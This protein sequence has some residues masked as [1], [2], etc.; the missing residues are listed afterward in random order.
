[1]FPVTQFKL[2][3]YYIPGTDCHPACGQY[4]LLPTSVGQVSQTALQFAKFPS[5]PNNLF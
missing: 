2:H 4:P 3:H 1:M 5:M